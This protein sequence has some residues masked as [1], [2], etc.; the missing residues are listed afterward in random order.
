MV[1]R[2]LLL[3]H[4]DILDRNL[5]LG[6][7]ELDIVARKDELILVV[8]VRYRGSSSWTSG[9]GSID[10]KKVQRVKRAGRRLW[11]RR[12]RADPS[13]ERMRFDVASVRAQGV[14]EPEVDYV[15]A[16]F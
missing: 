4:C 12:F 6:A 5:R 1:A 14:Q 13:V 16:A 11:N 2:Y 15:A 9:L 7:L 8:E 3:R 10:Y